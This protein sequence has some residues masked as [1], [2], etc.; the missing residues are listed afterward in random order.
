MTL[1][2]TAIPEPDLL[3]ALP[4]EELAPVV[5]RHAHSVSQRGRFH[6]TS[7][8]QKIP[9]LG[10]ATFPGPFYEGRR[11]AEIVG[12]IGEALQWLLSNVLVMSAPED[13]NGWLCLTRRGLQL[14][15]ERHFET[16]RAAVTF[17]KT[18]L[19]PWIAEKVGC[20]LPEA[21]SPTRYSLPFDQSKKRSA[22]QADLERRMLA[23]R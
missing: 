2:E 10:G 5:L 13:D 20:H 11:Q 14:L 6:P 9:G 8:T 22:R 7:L 4:P 16:Y 12:A 19:H 23:W 15:D 18:L 3:L 21:I 1:L 17:P